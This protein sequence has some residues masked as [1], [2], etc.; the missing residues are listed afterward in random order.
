MFSQIEV[1]DFISNEI[2]G[3]LA[4][5]EQQEAGAH[6]TFIAR[7]ALDSG[8]T[9]RKIRSG[10][11]FLD[12]QRVVGSV[13]SMV[14][15]LISHQA[16]QICSSKEI[17]KDLLIIAG[18]PVPRGSAFSKNELSKGLHFHQSLEAASV[19]KPDRGRGGMGITAGIESS[20]HFREAW[21]KAAL[22]GK[23]DVPILVEEYVSGLDLRVYVVAGKVVAAATRIPP[24][25]V[26]DGKSTIELLLKRKELQRD[27]NLYLRRLP[28]V[29]DNKW[30]E[31]TGNRME[32]ILPENEIAILN[33]TSNL[34]KGG[35]NV[36][37]THMLSDGLAA[38][39]V[40]AIASIP[41]L[42]SGGVD[43]QAR[44][45][46]TTDGAVVL[47]I[48]AGANISVHHLPAYGDSVNVGHKIV[49]AMLRQI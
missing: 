32:T 25:V 1:K 6:I 35:E 2:I 46:R 34:S 36:D 4:F 19:V 20:E 47:E 37:V 45:P 13:Q 10:H 5:N 38:L 26:G 42:Q 24:F 28:I 30:M 44:S 21:A 3:K 48:N 39:A 17:M 29:I 11:Y 12:G 23:V 41:G 43:F 33:S 40:G 9:V 49:Q 27:K 15:S 31:I 22:V 14:T 18:I 8:L 16:V 7:A